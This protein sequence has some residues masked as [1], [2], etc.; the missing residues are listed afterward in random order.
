MDSQIFKIDIIEKSLAI[1]EEIY[2]QVE[3]GIYCEGKL[4]DIINKVRW[5]IEETVSILGTED[6][7]RSKTII[8]NSI[9]KCTTE[10]CEYFEKINILTEYLL[11]CYDK[12]SA[13][14]MTT[15]C[16]HVSMICNQIRHG[17]RSS[18]ELDYILKEVNWVAHTLGVV[19]IPHDVVTLHNVGDF[20]RESYYD[21]RISC[22][23]LK[24]G[25]S[26]YIGALKGYRNMLESLLSDISQTIMVI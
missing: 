16:E 1:A 24:M 19:G 2:H 3:R 7:L 22:E 25:L 13:F 17:I 12:F 8:E 14:G 4:S 21:S 20:F 23:K 11:E 6:L 5:N 26:E 9:I 15:E 10:Y 18:E